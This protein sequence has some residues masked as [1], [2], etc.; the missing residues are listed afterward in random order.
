MAVTRE[1]KDGSITLKVKGSLSIYE[2][3]ALHKEFVIAFDAC[4][5]LNLDLNGVDNCDTAGVQLLCSAKKTAARV[6]KS[7]G[8]AGASRSV[9][10]AFNSAG[11]NPDDIL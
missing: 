6:G 7:L 11:L 9:L 2:T 4:N 1:D 8:I 5:G 10:D 3:A